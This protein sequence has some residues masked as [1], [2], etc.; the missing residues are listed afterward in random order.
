MFPDT[1]RQPSPTRA[2]PTQQA[3][4]RKLSSC[5]RTSCRLTITIFWLSSPRAFLRLTRCMLCREVDRVRRPSP[6]LRP[7]VVEWVQSATP[8][9]FYK[10]CLCPDRP[11]PRP[12]ETR[13]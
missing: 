5:D 2:A 1:Q 9:T 8:Q 4:L 10:T 6:T 7:A 12:V 11:A 3:R 13:V